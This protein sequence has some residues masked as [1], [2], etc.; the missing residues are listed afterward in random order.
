MAEIPGEEEIVRI[1]V[2]GASGV[3]KSSLCNFL[4]DAPVF[5]V[6]DGLDSCTK[7]ASS[8]SF[9]YTIDHKEVHF[10]ITDTP[11]WFDAD[12]EE[13]DRLPSVQTMLIKI[14]ECIKISENGITAFFIVVPWER[15]S[16]DI[17]QSIY[18]M[19]DCFDSTQL[20]HVW[21]MF[22]KCKKINNVNMLLRQ[23][24]EQKNRGR[25]ASGL[26]YDYSQ[27][28][29]EQCFATDTQ[30]EDEK[31]ADHVRDCILKAMNTIYEAHGMIPDG[32]F[33]HQRKG[34]QLELSRLSLSHFREQKLTQYK[35]KKMVT[36]GTVMGLGM[37]AVGVKG[38]LRYNSLL[39][40][41]NELSQQTQELQNK[42]VVLSQQTQE[43]HDVNAELESV[44]RQKG[45]LT[46][47]AEIA[48]G[49]LWFAIEPISG[50]VAI[51]DGLKRIWGQS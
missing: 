35:Y 47:I 21:M 8:H 31:E 46:G 41:H 37:V 42:T 25:K 49:A 33:H 50:S 28:I 10:E 27:I 15:I 5:K 1:C 34:F 36:L 9:T 17:Q 4:C 7:F 6:S 19:R 40:Q 16:I 29:N 23:L 22:T 32:V 30:N 43:L 20:Q 3:G 11:G 44:N 48:A 2:L 45:Q 14:N 39:S 12:N 38:Y 24:L 51:L 26:I 18:L 13:K